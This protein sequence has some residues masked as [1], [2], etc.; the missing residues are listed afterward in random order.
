MEAWIVHIKSEWIDNTTTKEINISDSYVAWSSEKQALKWVG[1]FLNDQADRYF[2]GLFY[3]CQEL[4]DAVKALLEHNYIKEA[5]GL[6][7]KYTRVGEPPRN[8]FSGSTKVTISI[9]KSDFKGSPFE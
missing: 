7:N 3:N 2:G 6:A 5:I 8:G 9:N 4:R 1:E